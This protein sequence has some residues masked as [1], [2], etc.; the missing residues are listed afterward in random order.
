MTAGPLKG[1]NLQKIR[2]IQPKFGY[3]FYSERDYAKS[4]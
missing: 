2:E 1:N 4:S 3:F